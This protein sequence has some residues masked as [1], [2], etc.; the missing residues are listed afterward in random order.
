MYEI[1]GVILLKSKEGYG[2]DG[3]NSKSH[4]E[5]VELLL[6]FYWCTLITSQSSRAVMRD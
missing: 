1:K 4:Q 2:D 6:H 3:V 5:M